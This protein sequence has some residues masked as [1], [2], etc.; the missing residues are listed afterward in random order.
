MRN[1]VP[2]LLVAV[3]DDTAIVKV[4]GRANFTVSVNFKRVVGELSQTG[5][6]QFVLDLSHCVT[7]DSTFLGVLAATVLTCSQGTSNAAQ[8]RTGNQNHD[9]QFR[10][11]NPN[12]RVADL[13]ENLGIA[14]LFQTMHCDVPPSLDQG[15]SPA[16]DAAPSRE[17][18]FQ[19]CLEAHQTLMQL[20]PAN[21]AKFKDV[22]QFLVE[23]LKKLRSQR[24][25]LRDQSHQ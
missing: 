13:L 16:D 1:S 23:D 9:A 18:L 4:N 7:M 2:T 25:E 10:L 24:E 6:S 20:N 11:L 8:T 12:Q 22:A 21:I 3:A 5:F 15:L 14:E 17:E 19:A